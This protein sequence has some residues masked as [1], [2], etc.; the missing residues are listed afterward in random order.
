LEPRIPRDV[1]D[2]LRLVVDALG[3][4]EYANVLRNV[5]EGRVDLAI[6]GVHRL[7]SEPSANIDSL[8]RWTLDLSLARLTLRSGNSESATE[9]YEKLDAIQNDA[10][11]KN[12]LGIAQLLAGKTA[13]AESS[14]ASAV[15]MSKASDSSLTSSALSNLA[16][17][18]TLK[19][20]PEL[21]T[22]QVEDAVM[23]AP[24][25]PDPYALRLYSTVLERQGN[26][27]Q[28]VRQLQRSI[29]V[30]KQRNADPQVL[31]TDEQL[32][33]TLNKPEEPR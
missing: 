27:G 32:L 25:A 3:A 17:I 22:A 9:L 12:E 1:G 8:A 19:G 4:D 29:E 28:A 11:I 31:A 15:D 6:D 13:D 2:E 10:Q 5:V 24:N 23:V 18:S 16:L 20:K 7:A 21:A 33:N 30:R 14:F 26:E